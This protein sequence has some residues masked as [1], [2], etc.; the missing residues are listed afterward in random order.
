M[1]V[2]STLWQLPTVVFHI[3]SSSKGSG[4][5][6]IILQVKFSLSPV[7]VLDTD[8]VNAISS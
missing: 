8:G 3:G 4:L 5:T 2:W 7:K 1:E 6:P